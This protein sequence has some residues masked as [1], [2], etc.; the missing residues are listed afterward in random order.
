M[1][2]VDRPVIRPPDTVYS[3][4]VPAASDTRPSVPAGGVPQPESHH[5]VTALLPMSP[6]SGRR[7]RMLEERTSV[8]PASIGWSHQPACEPVER[9]TSVTSFPARGAPDSYL[10]TRRR[11]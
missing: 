7:P 3:R 9:R 2:N 11:S 6:N 5:W 1:V 10:R 4:Y 8:N